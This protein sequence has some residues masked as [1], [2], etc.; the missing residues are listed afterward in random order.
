MS[1]SQST[2][3][4]NVTRDPELQ[5]TTGGTA[6]LSFSIASN[7]GF[8]DAAGEWQE[9]VSYFNVVAWRFLAEDTAAVLEKG[10][11]VMVSGRLEQRSWEDKEGE[12]R[13]TVELIADSIGIQTRSI[14]SF[15]RKTRKDGDAGKSSAPKRTAPAAAK[16]PEDE[17]F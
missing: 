13:T 14:E 7:C 8:K 6:K 17:P 11:G 15:A 3:I 1:Q 16:A 9:K 10:V 4:G 5:Y 2:I 12:K